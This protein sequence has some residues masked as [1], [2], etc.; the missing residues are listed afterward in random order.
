MTRRDAVVAPGDLLLRRPDTLEAARG[1][2][3]GFDVYA[4]Q[5]DWQDVWLRSG[6]PAL[7]APDAAFLGWLRKRL[8]GGGLSG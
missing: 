8:A 4:L 5:A 3:P 6:R 2:A 1:L 7:R